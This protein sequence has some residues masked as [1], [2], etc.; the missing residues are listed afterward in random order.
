VLSLL[1]RCALALFAMIS[2]RHEF[3]AGRVMVGRW[4]RVNVG[5]SRS[6]DYLESKKGQGTLLLAFVTNVWPCY[7]LVGNHS[8]SHFLLVVV[9]VLVASSIVVGRCCG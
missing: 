6:Y 2:R 7:L 9:V 5:K 4:Q 8:P 3:C 1:V